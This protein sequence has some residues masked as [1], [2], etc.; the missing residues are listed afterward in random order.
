MARKPGA[1]K[2][3]ARKP[4]ARK[5]GARKPGARKRGAAR[6]RKGNWM[7]DGQGA[8]IGYS[9]PRLEDDRYLRGRGE[10]IADIR[11]TGMRDLAFVRSPVA[12]ARLRAVHKPAGYEATVFTAADLTAVRPI[13]AV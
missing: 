7:R 5:P 8:G 11:L 2:P 10:F 13:V 9:V 4:G 3:G 12:H 6:E 1:R